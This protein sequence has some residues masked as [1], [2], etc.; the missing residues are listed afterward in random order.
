M[1]MTIAR[2]SAKLSI[3]LLFVM[4]MLWCA[5][6]ILPAQAEMRVPT[7][8]VEAAAEPMA[9][10]IDPVVER[11]NE[12]LAT[13]VD[14]GLPAQVRECIARY[15]SVFRAIEKRSGVPAELLIGVATIESGGCTRPK[16]GPGNITHIT[17]VDER[18]R[19][20]AAEFAKTTPE[21]LDELESS[22]DAVAITAA[23][24]RDYKRRTD[25]GL[26]GIMAYERGPGNLPDE[27]KTPNRYARRVLTATVF[28]SRILNKE[29]IVDNNGVVIHV[30]ADELPAF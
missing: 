22:F 14:N 9:P 11:I 12:K 25:T 28:A 20:K 8:V 24:L 27:T 1:Q 29:P 30:T 13:E 4:M 10:V 19:T 26:T 5:V 21:A 7:D 17:L 16:N 6:R 2:V 15:A 3:A 23:V 18:H